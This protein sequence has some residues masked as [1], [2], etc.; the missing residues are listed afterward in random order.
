VFDNEG[1]GI[2]YLEGLPFLSLLVQYEVEGGESRYAAII[3]KEA[4][5]ALQDFLLSHEIGHLFS[6]IYDDVHSGGEARSKKLDLFLRS[7]ADE[8]T[9]LE[10]EANDFGMAVL[11]PAAYL[12]DRE[13]FTGALSAEELLD[14]FL[15]GTPAGPKLMEQMRR[16]I[17]EHIKRYKEFKKETAPRS[18]TLEVKWIEEKDIDS[19]LKL[20]DSMAEPYYWIR[21]NKESDIVQVSDNSVFLFGRPKEEIETAKP[22]DLVV[23]E[24]RERMRK[25]AEYRE[26]HKTAIYYFTEVQNKAEQTSRQVVVYSFPI[27]RAGEYVGAMAALKALDEIET[28]SLPA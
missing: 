16:R 3:K 7:S 22:G 8:N 1:V 27:L 6:H 28:E 4:H 12:A 19:L 13:M 10:H 20:I 9:F 24:E 17:S 18:L 2:H 11:F 15:Q 26:E 21:L 25:R 14:E 5:P 23:P